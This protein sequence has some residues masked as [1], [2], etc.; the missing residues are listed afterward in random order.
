M[1]GRNEICI[2]KVRA[3][4]HALEFY[5]AVTEY[6]GAR[7]QTVNVIFHKR[8]GY[9][10]AKIPAGIMNVILNSE[11][12]RNPLRIFDF[13]AFADFLLGIHPRA[14]RHAY[15]LVALLFQ[16]ICSYRAV[17]S[18]GETDNYFFHYFLRL[19]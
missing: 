12:S 5:H 6:T 4:H 15:D 14:K 7:R 19:L 3:I 10:F 1:T 9:I 17:Y 8:G 16:Q 2:E 18:A 13:T 11:L